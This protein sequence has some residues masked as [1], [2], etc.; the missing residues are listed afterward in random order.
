[1]QRIKLGKELLD[2]MRYAPPLREGNE[3]C[4]DFIEYSEQAID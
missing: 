1:M 4:F 3:N 2:H